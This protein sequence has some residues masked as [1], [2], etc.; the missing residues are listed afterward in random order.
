M[1][2]PFILASGSP[3]RAQLLRELELDFSVVVSDAPEA[4]HEHLTAR[5]L[6]QLN[7]YRKAH[8]VAKLHPQAV[9]LGADTVVCLGTRHFGKPRDIKEAIEMLRALSGQIHQVVTGC[10][11]ALLEDHRCRIFSDQTA[12]RFLKLNTTTI[13]RYLRSINPL[14]KAGGYAIQEHAGLIVDRITGSFTN[15]M[16]LPTEVLV[17]ELKVFGIVD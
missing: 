7:A 17:E 10:C 5:E 13:H 2:P 4:E 15:V 11:L 1:K 6:A 16:G 8:A 12:V 9:V 3:R 14:D